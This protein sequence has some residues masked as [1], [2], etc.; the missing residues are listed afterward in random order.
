MKNEMAYLPLDD[1]AYSAWKEGFGLFVCVHMTFIITICTLVESLI[2]RSAL[3]TSQ[4]QL[5]IYSAIVY[6]RTDP[7]CT[8]RM[9]DSE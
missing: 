6:F 2:S 5:Q 4:W 1:L 7:L 9:S 8:I 3:S